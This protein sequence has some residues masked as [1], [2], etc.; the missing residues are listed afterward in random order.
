[1]IRISDAL[2]RSR[3]RAKNGEEGFTLIEL[4][5]VVIIIGILAAIA[6]PVYIGVQANAKDSAVKSD[7]TNAKTAVVGYFTDKGTTAA[8]PALS[9]TAY[10]SYGYT[11]SPDT[12]SLAFNGTATSTA[13]CIDAVS[14]TGNKF[15]VTATG[16]V[17]NTPCP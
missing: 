2:E 12:T 4:L 17:V 5:V 14:T 3:D 10:Q 7:L 11:K 16:G 15:S 13:F 8:A 1:M 6:I 9:L